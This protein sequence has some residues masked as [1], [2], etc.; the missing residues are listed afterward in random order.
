MLISA[1]PDGELRVALVKDNTLYDLDIEKY[2]SLQKRGNIYKG[3]ISR[4]EPSIEAAFVDYGDTRHGFLP[5]KEVSPTYFKTP[6]SDNDLSHPHIKD[7]L[8]EKQEVLVQIDKEERGT[9]G[10]A[11]TTFISLAGSYLVLMP[12][13]PR[14]GGISRRIEGKGRDDLRDIM[15][16]LHLPEGMGV[17]IRTAGV[18][19]KLEELQ[20]D[21]DALLKLWDSISKVVADPE[22]KAP[23]L[24]YQESDVVVRAIRDYLRQDMDEII[25]DNLELYDKVKK[26][27]QEVRA[28]FLNKV[29]LYQS[30][31]PLFSFYKLEKQIESAYQR[32]VHLPSGGSIVIDHTEALVSIDVN[33]AKAKGGFDI[34]ETALKTN[35]EAA[36]EIARQLRL[37]DIGGL[38][39]IDFIDMTP[40]RNQREVSDRIR[41]ALKFDRARV[42]IGNISRFGLLEMSR[43]RLRPSLGESVRMACPRCDGQGTIRGI[44]SLTISLLHII[45]EEAGKDDTAEIRIQLPID[46]ATFMLNEKRSYVDEIEK[47]YKVRVLLLPNPVFETPNYLVKRLRKSEVSG[48]GK[49]E[50][51]YKFLE[52]KE[53]E[54]PAT[55]EIVIRPTEAPL[56]KNEELLRSS[57]GAE[58]S[59]FLTKL[60]QAF[61]KSHKEQKTVPAKTG[62]S[63]AKEEGQDEKRVTKPGFNNRYYNKRPHGARWSESRARRG[64]RGGRRRSGGLDRTRSNFKADSYP[65]LHSERTKFDDSLQKKRDVPA[66]EI[67]KP[68]GTDTGNISKE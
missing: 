27:L 42:Q 43:Q 15:S 4:I 3:I 35:L 62:E 21:L 33:S 56:V 67:N 10:A 30:T 64:N 11:L 60:K 52:A 59:G 1:A 37:R 23:C 8:N 51:S 50:A 57:S 32:V 46:L 2:G 13:N 25:V 39:V 17:I 53:T 44:E 6:V 61:K 47:R 31:I 48:G 14:A 5:I 12:N 68:Q 18:G 45:E 40:L 28:E 55:K 34:E 66:N 58:K 26:Y 19:K 65:E 22:N 38:I 54:M 29:K 36:D 20:W 24:V 49:N 41:E 16:Q 7:T 63:S 9:K